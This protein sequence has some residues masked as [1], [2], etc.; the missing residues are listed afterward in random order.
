MLAGMGFSSKYVARHLH[1][2]A[3]TVET[4]M[5]RV[6]RK[7]GVHSRDELIEFLSGKPDLR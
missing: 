6:Y 2:S 3:R 4:H 1:L 7:L 5:G